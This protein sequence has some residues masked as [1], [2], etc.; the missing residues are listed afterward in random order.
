MRRI[1]LLFLSVA[2]AV[3]T[4]PEAP[5]RTNSARHVVL[6]VWDGMR[7][8]F[9]NE[10]NTPTLSALARDGVTFRQH[11]SIYPSLTNVNSTVLATGVF[12]NRS[13]LL[14]NYEYRGQ[15]EAAKFIRTDKIETVRKGDELSGGHYLRVPTIPELLR[16]DGSRCAIAAG[17]TVALLHDR[18]LGRETEKTQGSVLIYSGETL[19]E[20]ALAPIE[21]LVGPF[22]DAGHPPGTL[23]DRWTMRALTETLW[24]D[25]VPRYSLLW[26]SEPDRAEHA[27]RPGSKAALEAIKSSDANLAAVLHALEEKGVRDQTDIL[28]ASDHGFST[29]EHAIDLRALMRAAGFDVITDG[30]APAKSGEVRVISNGGTVL[31][32]VTEHDPAAIRHLVAWLQQSDFAGVL[33]SQT[34]IPGTFPLTQ[35]HLDTPAAPDVVMAFRWND[36]RN[37]D[38]VP[39]MIDALSTGEKVEGTHGTLSKF[40]LHNVL[41][42]TGPDFRRGENDD[43]PTSNLDVAPTILHLLGLAPKEPLDGRVL[44]EALSPNEKKETPR[45]ATTTVEATRAFPGGLWRQ[46]LRISKCAGETYVDE[47]NGGLQK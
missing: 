8:D 28:I 18:N 47:G 2:T 3:A 5:A 36:G 33:F 26:L 45:V 14:A 42:A 46:Y 20:S 13:G 41:I 25:D 35:L 15:I 10:A 24:H 21:K 39:G 4:P 32:Y 17:K 38:G 1:I 30:Q 31:F 9:V 6:I 23:G 29:I 44:W 34:P 12:P 40:D 19:P 16:A 11:H 27:T 22:P 7:A 37:E 43:L